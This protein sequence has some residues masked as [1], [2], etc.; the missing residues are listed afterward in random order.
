MSEPCCTKLVFTL[1]SLVLV[2]TNFQFCVSTKQQVSLVTSAFTPALFGP[3]LSKSGTFAQKGCFV[4]GRGNI[5][6]VWCGPKK[7]NSGTPVHTH[8]TK[9][10]KRSMERGTVGKW[11]QSTCVCRAS[12]EELNAR[13]WKICSDEHDIKPVFKLMSAKMD[14]SAVSKITSTCTRTKQIYPI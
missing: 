4:L 9:G 13:I 8:W 5:N 10:R 12:E 11:N 7:E 6:T 1:V 3:L 2:W 14:Q